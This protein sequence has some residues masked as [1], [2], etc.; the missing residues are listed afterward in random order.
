MLVDLDMWEKVV[1]NLLSNALK[2]TLSGEIAV[3]VRRA[4]DH[5]VVEVRDTGTGI[6]ASELPHVFE[7]FR[8]VDGA[9]GRTH[10]GT[11]IGLAL[12]K[13]L[14]TLHG[15]T[16]DATS[17]LG[18]G[19]TF[20]VTMPLSSGAAAAARGDVAP[21]ERVHRRG[22]ALAARGAHQR[23]ATADRAARADRGR[24][25]RH[26]RLPAARARRALARGDG[27]RRGARPSRR[28]RG[29]SPRW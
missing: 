1:L 27:R 8:R 24:Q 21:R 12:V 20:T 16:I 13:E 29:T 18:R 5:M 4:G 14:V 26:A 22:D 23:G 19:S 25:R 9:K 15:G 7:R 11:G 28:S 3:R 17:E 2:Y 6:P 10:E